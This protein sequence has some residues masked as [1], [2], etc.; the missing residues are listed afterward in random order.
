MLALPQQLFDNAA[1]HVGQAEVATAEAMDE[2][3]V[4]DAQGVERRGV[5]VMHVDLVLGGEVAELV[6]RSGS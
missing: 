6:G 3:L 5:Q 2:L 4:V 1:M